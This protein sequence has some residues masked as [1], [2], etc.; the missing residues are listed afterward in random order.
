MPSAPDSAGA[1]KDRTRL[2]WAADGAAVA[3]LCIAAVVF[4]GGWLL[5]IEALRRIPLSAAE[6]KANTAVGIAAGATALL[7]LRRDGSRRQRAFAMGGAGLL[8]A[9]GALSALQW[10]FGF[11]FGIDLLLFADPTSGTSGN[12]P[13]RP[14]LGTA[15]AF[16]LIAFATWRLPRDSRRNRTASVAASALASLIAVGGALAQLVDE[17]AF[18]DSMRFGVMAPPTA[19][20]LLLLAM[21]LLAANLRRERSSAR[22]TSPYTGFTLGLTFALGLLATLTWL[23]WRSDV[24]LQAASDWVVHTHEARAARYL[25]LA[26]ILDIE[27]EQ[28]SYLLT[29]L[30]QHRARLESAIDREAAQQRRLGEL[31]LDEEQQATLKQVRPLVAS[32]VDFARRTAAMRDTAG[33]AAAEREVAALEGDNPTAGIRAVLRSM[34]VRSDELLATRAGAALRETRNGRRILVVGTM[35]CGALLIAVFLQLLRE[36]RLRRRSQEELDRFF[37][38]S[39]DL[40]G[41]AGIDGHFRRLNPAFSQAL[42]HDAA[43]LL[44]R[45]F[46]DFVHPD[47]QA[48]TRAEMAKLDRGE[49]TLAFENRYRC[50]D[51]SWRW[52]SWRVHPFLA[53]GLLYA[54]ARDVTAQ[55]RG[56][57]DLQEAVR[58]LAIANSELESFSYSVS[59]DLRAPLRSIDGFSQILL[60]EHAAQLDEEGRSH[61]GRVRAAAQ[62]MG[63][64][65]DDLLQLSRVARTPLIRRETD[66]SALA[67]ELLAELRRGEPDRAVE[68]DIEPGLVALADANLLRIALGNLLGNAWKF[69]RQRNPARIRLRAERADGRTTYRLEDNGAGFDMAYAARLFTPFQRLHSSREFEGTGIGLAIVARIVRRHGGDI[70]AEGELDRGATFAFSLKSDDAGS[71]SEDPTS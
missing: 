35:L 20:A 17:R 60:E 61:L 10:V 23:D 67:A 14:A 29:G 12:L 62:R 27:V 53:E 7:C 9:I 24:R 16:V 40:L 44:E 8:A 68:F 48:A 51:G 55:R 41:I 19:A 25:L 33:A 15:L 31:T 58:R 22:P 37:T 26:H 1:L 45:P 42:G 5:G 18:H 63:L 3:A 21:A 70:R 39:I 69:T 11:D 65:I 36:T 64:L 47:D 13:G 57:E 56:S 59:H 49:P 34:D 54:T 52:I 2:E 6:M 32:L 46:L 28:R 4:L 66:L 50:R 71:R 38:L 43:S 30:T